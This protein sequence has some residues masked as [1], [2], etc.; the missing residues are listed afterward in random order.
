M[1]YVTLTQYDK[2]YGCPVAFE[3]QSLANI[4]GEVVSKAGLAQLRIAETEKY[5]HVTYFF[6]GGVE[7]Q[8]P[9]E[10]RIIVPSPKDVPTY[11]YKP[12]MSAPEVTEK[13]VEALPNYDLV[14]LNFANPDMV[15][16]T[17]VVEAGIK[18][19]ETIDDCVKAV[20]EKTLSLGGKLLLLPTMAI[21]SKCATA[22]DPQTPRTRPTLCTS[23]MSR[24]N[25]VVLRWRV[26]SLPMC[27]Q[28]FFSCSI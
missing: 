27:R 25:P 5:P 28:H 1:H 7:K 20:V 24:N 4:L 10:D 9:G 19:V 26:V 2:T 12:E 15:G 13:V 17:G 16:H 21:A 8:Y 18:A 3:P 14:I 22:T 6:N 11:D 23:S